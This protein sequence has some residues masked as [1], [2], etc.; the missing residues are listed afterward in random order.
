MIDPEIQKLIRLQEKDM[1]LIRAMRD[2]KEIPLER[3]KL[4]V[5]IEKQDERMESAKEAL[6]TLELKRKEIEVEVG[7]LEDQ[8]T[9]YKN[10]QLDVKKNEEYQALTHEIELN[11]RKISDLEE[12]EIGI[13]LEIDEESKKLE[14]KKQVWEREIKKLQAEIEKMDEREGALK[15]EIM[16]LENQVNELRGEVA[17][18]YL[19]AYDHAK[20]NLKGK[21]P[22]V[23]PI[24]GGF[25][26]RSNMRVSNDKL[27]E[28]K[29]HGAPHFDD[30]T[31]CVVYIDS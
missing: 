21:P 30:I 26:K 8:V 3:H 31:G 24:E 22:F 25:C 6:R 13:M 20:V 2:L 5:E 19:Q 11:T 1:E 17:G 10:Q 23:S 12:E 27:I 16:A 29:I 18:E 28:A 7:R 9:R 14:E 4:K 15:E